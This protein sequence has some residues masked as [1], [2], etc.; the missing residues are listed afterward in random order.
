MYLLC[1]HVLAAC[2]LIVTFF[3]QCHG[4]SYNMTIT[5]DTTS[6]LH[7][8]YRFGGWFHSNTSNFNTYETSWYYYGP[9]GAIGKH[10]LYIYDINVSLHNAGSWQL[11]LGAYGNNELNL[12]TISRIV[13]SR[14]N[15]SLLN[16]A[17]DH[18][19]WDGSGTENNE[20]YEWYCNTPSSGCCF[21]RMGLFSDEAWF[22]GTP[23]NPCNDFEQ[24]ESDKAGV[25]PTIK[26]TYNPTIPTID[27]SYNPSFVIT[28]L[29]SKK[30]VV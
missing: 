15:S 24:F 21:V 23:R 12:L 13:W 10:T 9:F 2:L 18:Y 29:S 4:Y 1:L 17:L 16:H 26:P 30:I 6:S 7:Y 5:V 14:T 28:I 20:T 8:W 22:G 11:D 3:H 27:P 25:I 19:I